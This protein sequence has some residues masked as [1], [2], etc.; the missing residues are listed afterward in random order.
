MLRHLNPLVYLK[1]YRD[2]LIVQAQAESA[3]AAHLLAAALLLPYIVYAAAQG[4]W[5][6]VA[7]LTLV[8][9][10]GN[11]Y[12]ILHLRWVRIRIKRLQLRNRAMTW[13]AVSRPY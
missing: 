10:A 12:P 5:S 6:A 2:P 1:Q 13:N 11:V 7:W 9:I 8:Q 4:W 3:E